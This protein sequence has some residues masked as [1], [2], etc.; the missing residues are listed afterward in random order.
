MKKKALLTIVWLLIVCCGTALA[1]PKLEVVE[2]T[3]DFGEILKGDQVKHIFTIRNAGDAPLTIEKVKTSCGCTA[4][5][6][7][8]KVLAPGQTAE[9]KTNFDSTRF[10][11]RVK[12]T[13]YVNSNDPQQPEAHILL[14]GMIRPQIVVEP[15][16][17]R[18]EN[19]TPGQAVEKTVKISNFGK[20][21]IMLLKVTVTSQDLEGKLSAKKVLPGESV[22]LLVRAT[23]REGEERVGGYVV[24]LTDALEPRLTVQVYGSVAKK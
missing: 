23:A 12:K 22:D 4:A 21:P 16:P 9:I 11:G 6:L 7:S 18:L 10:K 15:D 2:T 20:T 3:Y 1:A 17:L 13:I 24:I 8:E 14:T 19:L 5:L